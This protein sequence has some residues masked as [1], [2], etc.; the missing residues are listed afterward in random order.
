MVKSL[1]SDRACIAKILSVGFHTIESPRVRKIPKTIN[2][3]VKDRNNISAQIFLFSV[4][5]IPEKKMLNDIHEAM[6]SPVK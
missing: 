6:S 3:L 5:F 2:A 4:L 1:L